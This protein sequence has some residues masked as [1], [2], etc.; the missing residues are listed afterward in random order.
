[1]ASCPE[2]EVVI[3]GE[4][5]IREAAPSLSIRVQRE[6]IEKFKQVV[7]Y[8]LCKVGGKPN[9]G[10]TVMHKLL[11]FI[12]FDYYEKYE[13][14]LTGVQYIKNH[15]GPT[16]VV[17]TKV[18]EE[19]ISDGIVEKQ[20]TGYHGYE[21]KKYQAL[22]SPDLGCL[23]GTELS[24]IDSVLAKLADMNAKQ[25]EEYSHQDVPWKISGDRQV[26]PYESVFYRDD[27]YSVRDYGD[28]E[29]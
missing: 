22:K 14:N 18:I 13:E 26:I 2:N 6:D 28:D 8:I 7:L 5:N 12:D 15:H 24:H 27:K 1:M 20:R 16:S 17:F 23:N 19:M 4:P 9:I 21:Q 11:Y 25:I 29:I 10:E 3:E